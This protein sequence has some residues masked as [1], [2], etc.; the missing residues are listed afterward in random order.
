MS[1]NNLEPLD[2]ILQAIGWTPLVRL[3]R[4]ARGIRTPVYVK[5]ENHN[6]G[7]SAQA[8]LGVEIIEAAERK[9]AWRGAPSSK[10]TSGNTGVGLALAC[11]IKGRCVF[12]I[13][14][15]CRRRRCGCCARW[16]R[17]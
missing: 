3:N 12:T 1:P 6:P 9:G 14:V 5:A 16:E 11:A 17:K 4:I 13:P 15:R 7:G 10:T 2:N 8:R